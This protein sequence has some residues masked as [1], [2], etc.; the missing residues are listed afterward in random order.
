MCVRVSWVY[1]AWKHEQEK[2]TGSLSLPRERHHKL[3]L[4]VLN[5]PRA[6]LSFGIDFQMNTTYSRCVHNASCLDKPSPALPYPPPHLSHSADFA[7]QC[8]MWAQQQHCPH[9]LCMCIHRPLCMIELSYFAQHD[10]L[11]NQRAFRSGILFFNLYSFISIRSHLTFSFA[12]IDNLLLIHWESVSLSHCSF[13][14]QTDGGTSL[15]S[16]Q[17]REYTV[18]AFTTSGSKSSEYFKL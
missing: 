6:R 13:S 8:P 16:Q 1:L 7:M 2:H 18:S 14:Q 9:S 10:L 11:S 15:V 17:Q 4:V 3:R 12:A 5:P